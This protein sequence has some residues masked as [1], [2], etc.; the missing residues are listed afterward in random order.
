MEGSDYTTLLPYFPQGEGE[1]YGEEGLESDTGVSS[2]QKLQWDVMLDSLSMENKNDPILL[3]SDSIKICHSGES[4]EAALS[5]IRAPVKY[6]I[7][8]S[9]QKEF[10]RECFRDYMGKLWCCHRQR[11]PTLG[12]YT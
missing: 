1:F 2:F 12:M 10:D 8:Y 5:L 4:F 7:K 3:A 6:I 11:N 9:L